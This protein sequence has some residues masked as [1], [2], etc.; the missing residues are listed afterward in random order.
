MATIIPTQGKQNIA[1][2]MATLIAQNT[3]SLGSNERV[4]RS[5]IVMAISQKG[6]T[7]SSVTTI[8]LIR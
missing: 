4:I 7:Q 5:T 6:G 8:F 3:R 2:N 1:Q